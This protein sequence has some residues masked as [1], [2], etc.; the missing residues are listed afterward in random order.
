MQNDEIDIIYVSGKEDCYLKLF[1]VRP[2]HFLKKPFTK[3]S[4]YNELREWLRLRE[5]ETSMFSYKIGKDTFFQKINDIMYFE[6]VDRKIKMVTKS[7]ETSFYGN[8]NQIEKELDKFYFVSVHKSYL[9]NMEKIKK[10]GNTKVIMDNEKI[11]P[12]SRSKRDYFLE[13]ILS[14]ESEKQFVKY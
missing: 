13:K 4:I 8:I 2:M 12:I 9:I 10:Y 6:I 5:K 3:E 1:D 11:I 14:F 7:F